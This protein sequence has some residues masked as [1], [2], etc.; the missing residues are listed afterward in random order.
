MTLCLP[1]QSENSL[2]IN[3]SQQYFFISHVTELLKAIANFHPEIVKTE[4]VS[5]KSLDIFLYTYRI[6][7]LLQKNMVLN[8]LKPKLICRMVNKVS[9]LTCSPKAFSP[10]TYQSSL[11]GKDIRRIIFGFRIRILVKTFCS[12]IHFSIFQPGI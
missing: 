10:F 6:A 12:V 9:K 4:C 8:Q 3:E 1:T 2:I 5:I 11:D 7:V